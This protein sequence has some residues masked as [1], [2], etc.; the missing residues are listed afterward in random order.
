MRLF[1]RKFH[2]VHPE[3][4]V[5]VTNGTYELNASKSSWGAVGDNEARINM[6]NDVVGVQQQCSTAT[7]VLSTGGDSSLRSN[8]DTSVHNNNNINNSYS[9]NVLEK[10]IWILMNITHVLPH[11]VVVGYW[12]FV[13]KYDPDQPSCERFKSHFILHGLTSVLSLIDSFVVAVPVRKTHCLFLSLVLL[14]YV[15]FSF[16][17]EVAGGSYRGDNEYIY[18][19]LNW[20]HKA[21]TAT[22]IC[23]FG[24]LI[25]PIAHYV[26]CQLDVH[27]D[28]LLY[29]EE[30]EYDEEGA[31][32]TA[33]ST[34]TTRAS[35]SSRPT[36]VIPTPVEGLVASNST[37]VTA[38]TNGTRTNSTFV[39]KPVNGSIFGSE[40]QS[41]SLNTGASTERVHYVL[42]QVGQIWNNVGKLN[43][44][45]IVDNALGIRNS[46]FV[47]PLVS[48]I[49]NAVFCN[50]FTFSNNNC[51][52]RGGEKS[53]KV[54]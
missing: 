24:I 41:T 46:Q 17:Y 45:G 37:N 50:P 32:T 3:S 19:F 48:G 9:P 34:S 31:V 43:V 14:V 8:D 6:E 29:E 25:S 35:S 38:A 22:A 23:I 36:T 51:R 4:S 44:T 28:E 21:L 11:I 53:E 40:V 26:K 13:Y 47:R 30:E 49:L 42:N 16:I 5:G 12:M 33:K 2:H 20:R 39:L 7:V 52:K 27:I 15:T 54:L 1:R 18:S 10:L